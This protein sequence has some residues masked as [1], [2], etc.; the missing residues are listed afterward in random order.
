MK[1]VKLLLS[2]IAV[3]LA[4]TATSQELPRHVFCTGGGHY[5]SAVM[6]VSWTI[7]QAEPVATTSQPTVIF[8]PGF[9][10][11]D[12]QAVSIQE[13]GNPGEFLVYPNPCRD[14]VILDVRLDAQ[15]SLSYRLYDF[16][17]KL[18]LSN[19]FSLYSDHFHEVIRLGDLPRGIY[20]LQLTAEAAGAEKYQK[21]IKLIRN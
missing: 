11:Y 16:S 17:G 13:I 10:Q 19:A 7:G 9:Q 6:Q 5:Q 8:C 21:S 18:L 1:N 2:A 3:S 20:N 12:D 15:S 4:L 14:F